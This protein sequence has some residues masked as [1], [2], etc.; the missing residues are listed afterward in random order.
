[1]L[2]TCFW[3]DP[4]ASS[5]DQPPPLISHFHPLHPLGRPSAC[6]PSVQTFAS[7]APVSPPVWRA[8]QAVREAHKALDCLL[9]VDNKNLVA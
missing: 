6:L 5:L 8:T 3:T 4:C 1:M 2:W 7:H 9:R